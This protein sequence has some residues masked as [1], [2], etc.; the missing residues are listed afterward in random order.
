MTQSLYTRDI[1]R[2]AMQLGD[3]TELIA[4]DGRGEKRAPICGSHVAVAVKLS[5]GGRIGEI[6]VAV[7]ACA[8]GQASAAILK[9]RAP[10][11]SRNELRIIRDGIAA[12]L[13]G[14][15][16]MP[17]AWPQ[18]TALEPAREYPA[19]HGAVLLP[20]DALLTAIDDATKIG[21]G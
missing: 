15:A 7:N 3:D 5:N 8:I 2:L 21:S 17:A 14:D 10:G 1:L 13:S 20:Y 4:P 9:S 6:S 11:L 18:L 19:R 12:F 16:P